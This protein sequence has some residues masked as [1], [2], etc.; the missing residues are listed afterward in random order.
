MV[1]K[2]AEVV[3]KKDVKALE[4]ISWQEVTKAQSS[5]ELLRE[6][7]IQYPDKNALTFLLTGKMDETPIRFTYTQL[8]AKITQA[9]NM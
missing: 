9:A 1:F 8:L 4:S 5:Y 3:D 7:A 2:V 6:V